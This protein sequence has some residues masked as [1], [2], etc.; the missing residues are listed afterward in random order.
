QGNEDFVAQVTTNTFLASNAPPL[1]GP[2]V[3]SEIMYHPPEVAVGTNVLDNSLDEFVELQN[4]TTNIVALYLPTNTAITWK[5]SK[6]VD[7]SFPAGVSIAPTS[8]ALVVNFN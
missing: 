2:V 7:F 8:L 6:A 4:I 3:I 1:V 5:L